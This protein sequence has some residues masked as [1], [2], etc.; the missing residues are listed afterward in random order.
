MS[1]AVEDSRLIVPR[2]PPRHI[3]RPRL[4][5][6]L[7]RAS[8]SPLTLLSA[9]PGSGKTVLL[10]DWV[11]RVGAQVAW[12]SP[13]AAD[14][15]PRRFWQLLASALY[16]VAGPDRGPAAA[17]SQTVSFDLVQALLSSMPVQASPLIVVIDDAHVLDRPEVLEGLDRLIRGAQSL[18]FVLSARSDP[19]LPL[20][21]YRLGGQMHE[22]RAADL[23]L[24]AGEMREMLASYGVDLAPA[25]FGLL[26]GRTEGWA[27][28]VRLSAMRMEGSDQPAA[29]V[30]ELAL[31]QGSI[32][33]YLVDEVLR[34]LPEPHRRLLAETSF[35]GEVSGPL[36]DA[37]TGMAGCGEMLVQLARDNSFVIPLDAAQTRF[38]YHQLLA[39][40]LRYLLR[41][42]APQM[43]PQ[44]QKRAAAWFEAAGDLGTALY[45]A[46]QAADGPYVASLLARGGFVHAFVH[47]QDLSRTGLREL[48]PLSADA[49]GDTARAAEL[50]IAYS[51]TVAIFADPDAAARELERLA[52]AEADGP[53]TDP[54]L[55]QTLNV[56]QLVLGQKA[57]DADTVEDT[58]DRLLGRSD[59]PSGPVTPEL[60]AAV[61]LAQA[62]TYL[63]HGRY[64]HVGPALQQAL[65]DAERAGLAVVEL[66]VLGLRALVAS[67]WARQKHAD[68]A[69]QRARILL[70]QH[71]ELV[72]PPALDLAEALR[73]QLAS[74]LAGRDRVLQRIQPS[75][76]VGSDPGLKVT[77]AL[78]R[79][80]SL[81]DRE[82]PNEARG[83]LQAA[84]YRLPPGLAVQRDVMLAQLDIALGRPNAALTLLRDHQGSDFAVVA[85]VTR[86]R[87]YIALN[88]LDRA[89]TCVRSVLT[90]ASSQVDRQALV[91]AL[92]C[93]A[94]IAQLSNDRARALEV[95]LRAIEIARD[96]IVLPFTRASA[97]FAEL[98]AR[99]PAVAAQWPAPLP[100]GPGQPEPPVR[101][102]GAPET[103]VPAGDLPDPLT[104]REQ[105]VLRFLPT[106]MST[107][108]I[109]DE[110]CLSVNTV[111][112]HLA[113]IYR[114]LPA[115]R[116]REAVQRARQLELI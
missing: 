99:H 102:D 6:E 11:G 62:A 15:E 80:G 106:S 27:A 86:A 115:S 91:D 37:V 79:A 23:A 48:L 30:S 73:L 45:W 112:T 8:G 49:A 75:E 93:E 50:A 56:V 52:A 83:V 16:S 61:L 87:A 9:G 116:R 43:L 4:L 74:D 31:D 7:D 2:L 107:A 104:Q 36:A 96:D 114:K 13:T 72:P 84:G 12:L 26:A 69:V 44:L 111:K 95:I 41:R 105:A 54:G 101:A 76:A 67:R 82:Q 66:E 1:S 39:E 68:E 110:L 81:L 20:H 92:L 25:D 78:E 29:F 42:S 38:R 33:E 85:A 113:A 97:E 40:I 90:A 17:I 71:G 70:A 109:A 18:R 88:D 94:Q 98:L 89:K 34:H 77:L 35:L 47:R 63:W 5:S 65:A 53:V 55:R 57:G 32:G 10:S 64:E 14:A 58:A 51:A 22:L 21:R 60:R 100:G 103:V 28:G 3:S 59:Q 46:V 19:L 108:E 24:C